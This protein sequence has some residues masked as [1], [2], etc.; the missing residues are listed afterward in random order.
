MPFLAGR[1]AVYVV[2]WLAL[3]VL[4]VL[5][6]LG[7]GPALLSRIAPAGLILLAITATFA[8]IDLTSSLDP[9]F[10][11]SVYGMLTGT[12]MVLFALAIAMLFAVPGPEGTGA[13]S[14]AS[15]CSRCASCGS[16]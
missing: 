16:I 7:R 6:S 1:T 12:G 14:W 13:T 8:A 3:A 9:T 10:S 4:T 11:S 2:V 15:C 5:G